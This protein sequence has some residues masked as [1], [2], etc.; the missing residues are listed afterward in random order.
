MPGICIHTAASTVEGECMLQLGPSLRM[1][2]RGSIRGACPGT[3]CTVVLSSL[4]KRPLPIWLRLLNAMLPTEF[5]CPGHAE[6]RYSVP[7]DGDGLTLTTHDI[8]F[9]DWTIHLSSYLPKV[10]LTQ[11]IGMLPVR[12]QVMQNEQVFIDIKVQRRQHCVHLDHSA[13]DQPRR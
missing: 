3:P 6:L 1:D 11:V 7:Y 13:H 12:V 5:E 9:S 10:R 8:N 4:R 2:V